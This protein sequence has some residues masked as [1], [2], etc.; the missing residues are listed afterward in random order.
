MIF[1]RIFWDSPTNANLNSPPIAIFQHSFQTEFD[2][3]DILFMDSNDQTTLCMNSSRNY[4][5]YSA[6]CFPPAQRLHTLYSVDTTARY[7]HHNIC[8]IP[9]TF[10]PSAFTFII[11]NSVHTEWLRLINTTNR[12]LSYLMNKKWIDT[13]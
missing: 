12:K 11:M 8:V 5:K 7:I 13:Q 6:L 9:S 4:Y 2:I 1:W 10:T 3:L